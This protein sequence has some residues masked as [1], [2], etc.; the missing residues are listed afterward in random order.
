[1]LHL[2]L[3][4]TKLH[5]Y[6]QSEIDDIVLMSFFSKYFAVFIYSEFIEITYNTFTIALCPGR[7]SSYDSQKRKSVK[8]TAMFIKSDLALIL[9]T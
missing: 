9:R 5:H 6:S 1:M 3:L 4:Y 2:E 7:L 8:L